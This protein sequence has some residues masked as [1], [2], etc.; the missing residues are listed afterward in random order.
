MKWIARGGAGV[1][2]AQRQEL[3]LDPLERAFTTLT[4]PLGMR[5]QAATG[6]SSYHAFEALLCLSF[7]TSRA[8]RGTE[9]RS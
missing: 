3:S 4:A 6:A 9:L 7:P 2:G 8:W 5:S 1:G